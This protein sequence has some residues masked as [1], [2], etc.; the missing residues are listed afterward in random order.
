MV[1]CRL[2]HCGIIRTYVS[3]SDKHYSYTDV[4]SEIKCVCV[5]VCT[6]VCVRVSVYISVCA[7]MYGSVYECMYI[8]VCIWFL[9]RVHMHSA[10][11]TALRPHAR[12]HA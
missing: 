2:Y 12:T 4:L 11:L 1:C 7:R 8:L 10:Y 3:M 9:V 5:W 6:R